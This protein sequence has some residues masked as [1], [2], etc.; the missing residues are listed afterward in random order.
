[1]STIQELFLKG[2][3]LLK[4]FPNPHLETK[5][6]LLFCTSLSEEQLFSSPDKKL[7]RRQDRCFFK[8][9]S[10]RQEGFPL[11]Y[12]T[13]SKEFWSISFKVSSAVLIPRP[14]TELIVEKVLELSS[15][16]D[17][18]IVDIGTGCGNIAVSLAKE[19]PRAKVVATDI[20]QKVLDIAKLNAARHKLTSITFSRGS[21]FS[22]LK[23]LQLNRKCNFIV[24]NPPYVSEEEW[25]RLPRE[26]R[27]F[28][29]KSSLVAGET[30]VEV[31]N[32]I[33]EGAFPYLKP[34][35]CLL[36]EIGEGQEGKVLSF[37]KSS[38]N[39]A[40]VDILKDLS[41]IPRIILGRIQE[42][43]L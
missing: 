25:M 10:K 20:E 43:S 39:W 14:E 8:L 7:S 41:G 34:G 18:T 9:I 2:K 40:A 3:S 15:G 33:V 1:L 12:L 37:F 11:P 16:G 26:I 27:C 17:E 19:L 4:D 24:S 30:G 22:P 21:L 6:L 36:I 38:S 31:L 5:L 42:N 35:G 29:P 28:E 13:G 32:K 23:R